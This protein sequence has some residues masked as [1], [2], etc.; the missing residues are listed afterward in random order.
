MK[1][2]QITS[3]YFTIALLIVLLLWSAVFFFVLR[4]QVISSTDYALTQRKALFLEQPTVPHSGDVTALELRNEYIIKEINKAQFL[5][6][7]ERFADTL[8]KDINGNLMPFRLLQ[9]KME[10]EKKFYEVTILKARLEEVEI[11]R[12]VLLDQASM[13]IVLVVVL[14]LI[15][16]YVISKVWEPFYRIIE[17]MR[18]FDLQNEEAIP[19]EQFGVEEFDD[20]SESIELLTRRSHQTYLDQREFI[21]NVTH[22]MQTPL[23]I[24]K[25]KIELMLQRPDLDKEQAIFYDEMGT[26]I[27]RLNKFNR[28]LLLL[29]KIENNYYI[30][31]K[32]VDL[33]ELFEKTIE[34]FEPKI[35]FKQLSV[36]K[37]VNGDNEICANQLLIE[38][39][40]TNLIKNALVHNVRNGFVHVSITDAVLVMTN[41]GEQ[42]EVDPSDLLLR[43]RG[44]NKRE[45][46]GLGF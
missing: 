14:L 11:L 17:K 38:I 25:S 19:Q 18:Q 8:L 41:S 3:R 26:E 1:L 45:S 7:E 28:S 21:E 44:S 27:R 33:A 36:T 42:P 20:L 29:S 4:H 30:E 22:E 2:N 35:E 5:S 39:I 12:S 37:T 16:R 32:K 9:T 31:K 40:Y 13:F 46:S 6:S 24:M 43:Y 23:A 15:N 34:A 10:H